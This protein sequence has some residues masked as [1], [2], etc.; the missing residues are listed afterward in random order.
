MDTTYFYRSLG[1]V[2]R[3]KKITADKKI[4]IKIIQ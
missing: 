1:K 3:I 4:K 2:R